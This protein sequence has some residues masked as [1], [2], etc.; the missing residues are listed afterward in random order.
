MALKKIKIN[1]N[2]TNEN[3]DGVTLNQSNDQVLNAI[4]VIKVMIL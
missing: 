2:A 1:H 4:Q 3:G